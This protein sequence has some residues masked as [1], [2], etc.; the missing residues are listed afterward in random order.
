MAKIM[1]QDAFRS[2][3]GLILAAAGSAVGL[4]NLWGFPYKVG[5]NGGGF[6]IVLYLFFAIAVG[7]PLMIAEFV[8]GKNAKNNSSIRMFK[9]IPTNNELP[10]KF[11][12]SI[13]ILGCIASTILASFY[14]VIA[15]WSFEYLLRGI[16]T[17][18]GEFAQGQEYAEVYFNSLVG[19]FSRSSI[20]ATTFIVLALGIS[21]FGI[22]AGVEKASKIL[23][24]ILVSILLFLVVNGVLSSGLN[25]T[26]DFLLTPR[27]VALDGTPIN[28]PRTVISAMSQAFFSLSLGLAAM[29]TYASYMQKDTRILGVS[30]KIVFFD[31]CVAF[32]AGFAIF[33]IV[34]AQGAS[35]QQGTGLVFNALTVCFA[36]LRFGRLLGILTFALLLIA[37]L[38]SIVAMVE[39]MISGITGGTKIK[40]QY[41]VMFMGVVLIIGSIFAQ[42]ALGFSIPILNQLSDDVIGQLD[43]LVMNF[44]IPVIAF[45]TVIFVGF[46]L[47][48]E[49]LFQE[50]RSR[51]VAVVFYR[52][53]RYVIPC[54]VVLVFLG[55]LYDLFGK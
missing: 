31:T 36:N 41:A 51:T 53:L 2:Q 14:A 16:T 8:I 7:L 23:M 20:Y 25:Q 43:A 13:G 26:V 30:A 12:A 21:Y 3:V 24:P 1:K 10:A 35:P 39:T 28:I 52:Y 49:L 22:R 45:L 54:L 11:F 27:L 50:F 40:R 15:G 4:G 6:F 33:P 19:D 9:K 46:R 55:G 29:I 38:T 44:F 32:L 34:F 37:A 18:Y 17:G 48:K 42:P 47:K 5:E